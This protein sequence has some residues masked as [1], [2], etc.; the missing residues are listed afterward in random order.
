[1]D[2]V[3]GEL[4]KKVRTMAEDSVDGRQCRNAMTPARQLTHYSMRRLSQDRLTQAI[5][6]ARDGNMP[7]MLRRHIIIHSN[8]KRSQHM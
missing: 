4:W 6:I 1:M 3:A 8:I 7:G 2:W 5:Y